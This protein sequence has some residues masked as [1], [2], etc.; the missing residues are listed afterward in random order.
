[1]KDESFLHCD[2]KRRKG[3][4]GTRKR[5]RKNGKDEKNSVYFE[6]MVK[7]LCEMCRD[8]RLS[9]KEKELK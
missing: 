5:K 9:G 3:D 1:M 8:F 7:H 6:L 2:Q 4:A